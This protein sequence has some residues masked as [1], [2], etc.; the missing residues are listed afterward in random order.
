MDLDGTWTEYLIDRVKSF[1]DGPALDDTLFVEVSWDKNQLKREKAKADRE[2]WEREM[3]L[4]AAARAAE[5][6][7]EERSGS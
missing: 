5:P 1:R 3:A 7:S 2:R 4:R 6:P